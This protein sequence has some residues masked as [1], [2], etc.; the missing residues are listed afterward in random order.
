[1]KVTE[2]DRQGRDYAKVYAIEETP[3]FNL[4]HDQ[5]FKSDGEEDDELRDLDG[6]KGACREK[7]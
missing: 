2:S 6:R 7:D 5:A 3:A 4:R 1:M